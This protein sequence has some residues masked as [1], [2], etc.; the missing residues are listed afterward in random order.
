M[1]WIHH[2]FIINIYSYVFRNNINYDIL[3]IDPNSNS[4]FDSDNDGIQFI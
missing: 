2:I 4:D 3:N 1:V